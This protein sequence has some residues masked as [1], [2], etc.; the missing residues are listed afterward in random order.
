MNRINTKVYAIRGPYRLTPKCDVGDIYELNGGGLVVV[1]AMS[2]S[3]RSA[4][5]LSLTKS[6][7][8]RSTGVANREWTRFRTSVGRLRRIHLEIDLFDGSDLPPGEIEYLS[9]FTSSP[10][11]E[12]TET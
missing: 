10:K 7:R 1:I 5:F 8:V 9:W 12:S 4:Y 2:K 3:D 11:S 6:G